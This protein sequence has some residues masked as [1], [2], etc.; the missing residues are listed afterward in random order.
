MVKSELFNLTVLDLPDQTELVNDLIFNNNN[1][2][3]N[4]NNNNIGK[5]RYYAPSINIYRSFWG[6]FLEPSALST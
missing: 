2:N 6:K 1:N 5:C 3:N 4:D